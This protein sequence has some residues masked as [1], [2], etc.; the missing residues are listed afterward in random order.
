M[1]TLNIIGIG[2]IITATVIELIFVISHAPDKTLIKDAKSNI[3][4]GVLYF[5]ND[6]LIKS[7]AFTVF[8]ICYYYSFF[9]P[10]L[11]WKLWVVGFLACDFI[12]YVY[13]WLGHNTRIFW[14]P[15]VTHHS[16]EYFNMTHGFRINF[17]QGFYRFLY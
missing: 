16:S 5:L 13:H 6:L 10:E 9:K 17:F 14:A 15:H 4:L 1:S 8:S 11:S 12:H 2:L 7:V 3:L